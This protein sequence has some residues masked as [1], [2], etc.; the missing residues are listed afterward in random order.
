[1]S[2]LSVCNG[3]KLRLKDCLEHWRFNGTK[4]Y[5]AILWPVRSKR[6]MYMKRKRMEM[7]KK[8]GH[9][10]ITLTTREAGWTGTRARGL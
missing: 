2:Y 8:N 1:M 3:V 9:Q 4:A 10:T 6:D 7:K 5:S